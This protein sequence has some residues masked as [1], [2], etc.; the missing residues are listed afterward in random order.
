[1]SVPAPPPPAQPPELRHP[2]IDRRR[3]RRVLRF[4]A[5]VLAH[6]LWWDVLLSRPVLRR[7]RTAPLERWRSIARRYRELALDLGGVLIKLGQF[8]STRVDLLP[9]PVIRELAGLQD[10]VP[11]AAFPAV[12]AAIE[13]DLGRP[14][15]EVFSE[16]EED[17]VG[18]ASLAQV[19]RARL[20]SGE[21]VVV[22]V[23]RPGIDTLVETDLA[24]LR[25]ASRWLTLS[26]TIRRRVDVAWLEREFRSVTRRELDLV[27]EGRNVE[28]FAADFGSDPGVAVPHVHWAQ[29]GRRCLTLEDVGAIKITDRAAMVASGIDPTEVARRLY[30]V[31]MQQFFVTHFVHADPHPGNIFVR[32]VPA[33]EPTDGEAGVHP[34]A[35][36]FVI[37]FVDFGMMT[38]IP[39]R[40]RAAL[41]EFAIGL[42]TRD[43]RRMVASYVQAGTLL[44][45]ADLERLVAAHEDL[46][47]RFWGIRIG[48]MRDVAFGEARD[49]MRSYHDLLLSAPVQVQADMLFALRAVGL[50]AGLCTSLDP[51]FDPWAATVPFAE[52]FAGEA[53]RIRIRER[54]EELVAQLGRILH[55]PDQLDAILARAD[56][57]AFGVRASLA[58]D[59]GRRLDRL[60]RAV[61]RLTW[62]IAAAGLAILGG[63]LRMTGARAEVSTVLFAAAAFAA[64]GA[65]LPHRGT[66]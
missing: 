17:A 27:S 44:E 22:K 8:L 50:L 16:L 5:G 34:D 60:H 46:L 63:L 48:R 47:E 7:L 21:R 6:A 58:S 33:L 13:A 37:A 19:H 51:D 59:T 28:R 1:M 3:Y 41:R 32:P 64:V 11:A 54:V 2:G 4:L 23:L 42:G 36:P 53:V 52:R 38:E 65:V 24:A 49:L 14:W 26:R 43:A 9:E 39:E 55:L 15:R 10:E 40:L 57:S 66:R 31:F 56:R 12:L 61:A 62:T 30:A 35:S 25:R 45:E 29:S 18:A 20:P